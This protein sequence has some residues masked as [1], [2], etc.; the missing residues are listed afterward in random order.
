[1][2]K[3]WLLYWPVQL[4]QSV[5]QLSSHDFKLFLSVFYF[6]SEG[7]PLVVLISRLYQKQTL[8]AFFIWEILNFSFILE[9]WQCLPFCTL[10]FPSKLLLTNQLLI[11]LSSFFFFFNVMSFL[12]AF[13]ILFIFGTLEFKN[14]VCQCEFLCLTHFYF[15]ELL[16]FLDA[17]ISRNLGIF[18]LLF[19]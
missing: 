14:N 6:P 10:T 8:S 7:L 1:M 3:R 5:L 11:L 9:D 4:L 16:G 12:S 18:Q 13:K 15:I 19:I 17:C 2:Q